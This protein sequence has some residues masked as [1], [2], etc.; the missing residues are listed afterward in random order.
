MWPFSWLG[1]MSY[2]LYLLHFLMLGVAQ[3]FALGLLPIE[4]PPIVLFFATFTLTL[5]F[6][7]P[8]AWI[9]WVLVEQPLHALA[10]TL[11][12]AATNR[13]SRA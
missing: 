13:Q 2:G 9:L 5:V 3:V 7:I 8:F 11:F 1:K 12:Q 4:T 10:L 6:T